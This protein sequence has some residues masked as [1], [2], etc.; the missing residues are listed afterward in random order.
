MLEQLA[1]QMK[2]EKSK[3]DEEKQ[4]MLDEKL[5]L[6]EEKE[7][8]FT[9]ADE[10]KK[11]LEEE[12]EN[13]RRQVTKFGEKGQV[14]IDPDQIVGIVDERIS[15]KL[16]ENKPKMIIPDP[17]YEVITREKE[18]DGDDEYWIQAAT[19]RKSYVSGKSGVKEMDASEIEYMTRVD[20]KSAS[21]IDANRSIG[22]EEEMHAA[23]S[24]GPVFGQ[25]VSGDPTGSIHATEK[26]F[27]NKS[28]DD[29]VYGEDDG[30]RQKSGTDREFRDRASAIYS[31][32]MSRDI[33]GGDISQALKT[34]GR[35]LAGTDIDGREERKSAAFGDLSS[36]QKVGS[37]EDF[38][39][40]SQAAFGG[41]TPIGK[42][43]E[44]VSGEPPGKEPEMDL[45]GRSDE[46]SEGIVVDHA[47]FK[48]IQEAMAN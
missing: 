42:T 10:L 22:T 8:Y 44:S 25:D 43:G 18:M 30:S 17:V 19:P 14:D 7:K 48:G 37:Q 24:Q 35:D 13:L 2:D 33:S 12:Q 11:N 21:F 40:K 15:Q 27:L 20:G 46:S 4:R 5:K 31:N 9:E 41:V 32:N 1:Q 47:P 45:A 28:Q 39:D 34:G 23:V 36:L 26:A 6:V 3:I 29:G 38:I 16:A